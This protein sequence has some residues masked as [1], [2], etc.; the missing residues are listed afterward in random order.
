MINRMK[1]D[2]IDFQRP[3]DGEG[4][5]HYL[6]D[7]RLYVVNGQGDDLAEFEREAS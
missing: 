2:H 5:F 7:I 1:R 3:I 4:I 6:P